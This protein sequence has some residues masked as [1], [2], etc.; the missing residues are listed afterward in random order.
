MRECLIAIVL[1]TSACSNA[2]TQEPADRPIAAQAKAP[3]PAPS[4]RAAAEA[5]LVEETDDLIEFTYGWS[6]EAA[7]VPEL[8][9][10][11]EADMAKQ[12][13]E[14]RKTAEEDRAARGP[15]IPFNGHYFD[16]T[17]RTIGNTPRL[18]SLATA[19]STYTGGAHGNSFY[20]ALLWDKAA[21]REIPLARLFADPAA[22]LRLI[23]PVYCAD[24]DRQRAQ[25]RREP[26]PL[27][28][29][30]WMTDCPTIGEQVVAPVDED[31][32]GRFEKLWV[33]LAPY[34]AGPYVEGSY[35]V[36]VPV[37]DNLKALVKAQYRG[38]F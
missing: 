5:R 8:A 33:M 16:E 31:S 20:Q 22:A 25:K 19:V 17:W 30:G 18:L 35:E 10:R 34:A 36:D 29:D 2:E 3:A 9:D 15:D 37:T 1:L 12:R 27:E 32:D 24:L 38:S 26:L 21:R 11:F 28:G 23:E 6:A 7:A 4:P 13:A 14:A